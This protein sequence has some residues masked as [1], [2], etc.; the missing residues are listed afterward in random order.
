L[1][2]NFSRVTKISKYELSNYNLLNI[3]YLIID[4]LFSGVFNSLTGKLFGD[5]GY[6]S[7]KLTE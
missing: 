1:C 5:K 2:A 4:S 6:I 7:E 3:D